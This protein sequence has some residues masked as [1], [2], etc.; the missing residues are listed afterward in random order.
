M[1]EDLF[2]DF[3]LEVRSIMEDAREEVPSH[4]WNSVSAS[5]D[6]L[7]ARRRSA[8]TWWKM[9]AAGLAAAAAVAV[10][11]FFS[12]NLHNS[13][14][15]HIS[16]GET[17]AETV[18]A[19]QTTKDQKE[20]P[21]QIIQAPRG[22]SPLIAR[23]EQA[24]DPRYE[25]TIQPESRENDVPASAE[26]VESPSDG[27]A[28]TTPA[29][30]EM[31]KS[32]SETKAPEEEKGDPFAA[33]EF[34]DS[35]RRSTGKPS[36]VAGSNLET[37][38]LDASRV[39]IP[40]RFLPANGPLKTSV[41]ELSESTY[42]IPLTFGLGVR[43]PLSP[44]VSIGTGLQYSMLSRSFR[45]TYTPVEN[46]VPGASITSD[47]HNYQH[48]IGIPVNVYCNLVNG[49][50]VMLY[51]FGGGTF[52]K[53]LSDSY[54][55]S[56]DPQTI[57]W[58]RSVKGIQASAAVGLGVEFKLAKGFGLYIDPALRYYFDCNQPESIRTRQHLMMNLD[59]GLR[60]D[61]GR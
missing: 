39:G 56:H 47:I 30:E 46:G 6:R 2:K 61:I 1:K 35:R 50:S 17:I 57:H 8:S 34:Q 18:Q 36:I 54:R 40:R 4:V 3:D 14:N 9:A 58:S 44:K 25:K 41:T 12:G 21:V 20:E 13:N 31:K 48:Y 42:G 7:D 27:S 59:L 10:G 51:V 45:G 29:R 38:T 24:G 28:A 49:Q 53:G 5:L 22:G 60:F 16:E 19:P 37:N 33:M 55:I 26:K 15:H 43:F 23:A 11:V 52:E 32:V